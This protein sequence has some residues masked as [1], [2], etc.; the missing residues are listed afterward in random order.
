M[1][2]FGFNFDYYKEFIDIIKS[3]SALE[4]QELA[5]KYLQEKDLTEVVVGKN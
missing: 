4:L 1:I 2:D 3:V 5:N